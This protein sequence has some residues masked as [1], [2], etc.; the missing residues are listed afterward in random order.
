MCLLRAAISRGTHP[1]IRLYRP[2]GN[3]CAGNDRSSHQAG[4]VCQRRT[5]RVR[6]IEGG[7]Q[8]RHCP[9][10]S[11]KGAATLHRNLQ[12]DGHA[13]SLHGPRRRTDAQNGP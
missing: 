2:E 1:S 3:Q 9:C 13:H 12:G 5:R 6:C 11:E 4:A 7:A 10:R 8:A